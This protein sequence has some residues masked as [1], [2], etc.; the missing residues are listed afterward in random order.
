MFNDDLSGENSFFYHVPYKMGSR[1]K[2]WSQIL[3]R[4][5]CS[6]QHL[7]TMESNILYKMLTIQANISMKIRSQAYITRPT[8]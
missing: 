1:R 7:E 2:V 4:Q 5:L 6:E 8:F 3:S